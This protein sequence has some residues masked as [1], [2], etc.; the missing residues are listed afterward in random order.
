MY[1][2]CFALVSVRCGVL[3]EPLCKNGKCPFYKSRQQHEADKIKYPHRN[4]LDKKQKDGGAD[5]NDNG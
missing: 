3:K 5:N 4:S 1:E 2:D